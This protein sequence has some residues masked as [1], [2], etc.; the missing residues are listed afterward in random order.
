LAESNDFRNR[1]PETY[2]IPIGLPILRIAKASMVEWD[3]HIG[4]QIRIDRKDIRDCTH[5]CQP[6]G[7]LYHWREIL[8]NL[9]LVLLE[10]N[11]V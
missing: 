11:D 3:A 8:Y 9:L 7:I 10:R 6:S 1:I 4:L 2:F 5:Y